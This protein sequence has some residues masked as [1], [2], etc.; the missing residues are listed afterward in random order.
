MMATRRP[1][2]PGRRASPGRPLTLGTADGQRDAD[3]MGGVCHAR[4]AWPARHAAAVMLTA[5]VAG[6]IAGGL[7]HLAGRADAAE[8]AWFAVGGC[9]ALYALWSMAD[10]LRHR[11]VGVDV[12]AL[13]AVAGAL[14][15]GELL[16][17]A[18][19]GVML[20][21][22]QEAIDVAVIL[23]ALRALRPGGRTARLPAG[24]A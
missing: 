3:N 23:N 10:S 19:I 9:G 22:L 18:V 11:R 6:L 14:A 16:A 17:A 2:P 4:R 5:T 21:L 7:L 8:A 15:V 12:I 20:A 1:L 24:A 13:L